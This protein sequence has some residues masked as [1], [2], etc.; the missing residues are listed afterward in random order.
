MR[1]MSAAG[2]L[3]GTI[4][5]PRL[6]EG[7]TVRKNPRA[8]GP[9]TRA[10]AIT[11]SAALT[12]GLIVPAAA[13][14]APAETGVTDNSIVLGSTLPLTGIASAGY[15][16]LAPA[17]KAYFDYVNA[18]GGVNGRSIT[19]KYYDD[20]YNPA[21]T[22]IE[23]K[24]LIQSD[25]IF[26]MFQALGTPTH[27]TVV[28]D[29]NRRKIPDLFVNTG[30]SGF[31]NPGSYP[32]TFPLFPSYVVEAK[33]MSYFIQNTPDLANKT[34]CLFYQ[35]GEFGD[36]SR[37][38]FAD[39]GLTFATTTSYASG[40]QLVSL[41][42][43]VAKLKAAN[44]QL[45]VFFGVTS[46]TARLLADAARSAFAPTW[47]VT[48]VGAD[49]DSL[50]TAGVPA[51]L[52]NGVYSPSFLP[53]ANDATDPYVA[54][55]KAILSQYGKGVPFNNFTLSAMNAAYLTAQALALTG[56]N[57]TRAG[58][59]TTLNT[60]GGQ[61]R[62]AG[63]SPLTYSARSHQ[64]YTGYYL[65]RYDATGNLVRQTDFVVTASN[66]SGGATKSTYTRPP[67]PAKLLP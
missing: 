10:L 37:R 45:V 32:M 43:Q 46:A 48:S 29:L 59:V 16:D 11:A 2:S 65:G 55:F 39:A 56:P 12:V 66:G 51:A 41:A 4:R 49:Y 18:N 7:S 20:E 23:T 17:A 34:R 3:R 53:P 42:P 13:A 6:W 44:C 50:I 21:K 22:P 1:K 8:L 52:V 9:L 36:D 40:Q 64:G 61:M 15:K 28:R 62:S 57:L 54:K 5:V 35:A 67:A 47:L 63:V 24:K 26:A 27:S 25:G 38:G 60:K 19:L 30:Y 58:L 14:P 33:S 31:D